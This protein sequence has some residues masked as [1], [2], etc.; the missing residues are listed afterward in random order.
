MFHV[1]HLYVF[2]RMQEKGASCIPHRMRPCGPDVY[3]RQAQVQRKQNDDEHQQRYARQREFSLV[4][5]AEQVDLLVLVDQRVVIA[6]GVQLG[7]VEA[8]PVSYTHLQGDDR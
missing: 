2:A 5:L 6:D 4:I 3:K 8:A 7:T 1:K